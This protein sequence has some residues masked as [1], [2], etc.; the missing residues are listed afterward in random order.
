VAVCQTLFRL[1]GYEMNENKRTG[2]RGRGMR[3]N[4]KEKDRAET[5][6]KE[7]N[8]EKVKK[9]EEEP[10]LTNAQSYPS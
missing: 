1:A 5:K 3:M 2:L 7:K 9:K 6:D 10:T 4:D 8:K